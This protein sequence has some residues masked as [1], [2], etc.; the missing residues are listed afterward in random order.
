MFGGSNSRLK[1]E[2][3]NLQLASLADFV[4]RHFIDETQIFSDNLDSSRKTNIFIG[5]GFIHFII[6]NLIWSTKEC[7]GAGLV[8]VPC[9][10]WLGLARY[11]AVDSSTTLK[12][13]V[14]SRSRNRKKKKTFQTIDE[15]NVRAS[16][17][18]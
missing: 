4:W 9:Y 11:R 3:A 10:C 7:E 1:A 16:R 8:S 15:S 12:L 6:Q 18:C 17:C 5:G 2:T 14:S 13:D